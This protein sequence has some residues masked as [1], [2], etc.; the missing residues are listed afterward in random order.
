VTVDV[1]SHFLWIHGPLDCPGWRH[2]GPGVISYEEHS[3]KQSFGVGGTPTRRAG[4]LVRWRRGPRLCVGEAGRFESGGARTY[5]FSLRLGAG[6]PFPHGGAF[7]AFASVPRQGAADGSAAGRIPESFPE[8]CCHFPR[9]SCCAD[10]DGGHVV[11]AEPHALVGPE[12]P[13]LAQVCAALASDYGARLRALEGPSESCRRSWTLRSLQAASSAGPPP[14]QAF[15]FT[16]A[17]NLAML[18]QL[19]RSASKQGIPLNIR[20]PMA[21]CSTDI[22]DADNCLM[23]MYR[24][25]DAF[26]ASL[27]PLD[28]LLYVDAYDTIFMSGLAGIVS[29]FVRGSQELIFGTERDCSPD[30]GLRDH[31]PQVSSPVPFL[32]GGVFLGYAYAFERMHR[33]IARRFGDVREC[34]AFADEGPS[35]GSSPRTYNDQRCYQWYFLTYRG[36]HRVGLDY[37]QRLVAALVD[38]SAEEFFW[39]P[40]GRLRIAASGVAPAILHANGRDRDAVEAL[41]DE[42]LAGAPASPEGGGV[43]DAASTAAVASE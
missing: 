42:L 10:D 24:S 23:H 26:A 34:R 9:E 14:R 2:E 33:A 4:G 6:A 18:G 15:V 17:S 12:P 25:A 38:R 11:C 13:S 35:V 1:T 39:D 40:G 16:F 28:L 36:S 30:P 8:E 37:D 29:N 32:N 7:P 27:H 31:F 41:L 5:A 20:G 22:D 3:G 21:F 43:G 19:R